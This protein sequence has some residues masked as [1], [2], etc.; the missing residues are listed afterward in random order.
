MTD[1]K[2]ACPARDR[3]C[4]QNWVEIPESLL[5]TVPKVLTYAKKSKSAGRLGGLLKFFNRNEWEL[6][7]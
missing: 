5:K 1:N 7:L 3:K 2:G 4:F 6:Q